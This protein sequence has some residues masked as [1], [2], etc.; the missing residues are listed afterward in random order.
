MAL[1]GS[2]ITKLARELSD[3]WSNVARLKLFASD[4][5]DVDLDTLASAAA[6]PHDAAFRLVEHMNSSWPP[7]DRELLEV[8]RDRGNARLRLVAQELLRPGYFSPN[9]EA[10]YAIL[11]GR[12]PFVDRDDLR[13][14]LEAFTNPGQFTPRVLVVRGEEPCGKSY[15]WGFLQHLA[16]ATVGTKPIRLRLKD[17]G[18]TPR[19]LMVAVFNLLSLD[20]RRLPEL[21]DEP[22]LARIDLLISAFQG[23][24]AKMAGER[25][26]LVIDD[27][28]DPSV[29]PA[30][31]DTVFA[32]AQSVDE[33]RNDYLW[34]VLLGFDAPITPSEMLVAE[35]YA[36]FPNPAQVA[37]HIQCVDAAGPKRLTPRRAK[38]IANRLFEAFPVIDKAAMEQLTPLLEQLSERVRKGEP[39][40]PRR[41]APQN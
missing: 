11:L 31:A 2:Q 3:Q 29:T 18:Y 24:L 5:L 35:E 37:E 15:T 38:N 13:S 17:K 7:R 22:Q 23:Q 9:G 27:V 26:W 14:K 16:L 10:L 1:T 30:I 40:W 36:Q 12:A 20:L 39:P 25:Y 21:T 41:R 19:E 28:N 34:L 8:L 32:V 33:A 4:E 6:T